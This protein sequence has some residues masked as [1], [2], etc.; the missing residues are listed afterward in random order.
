MLRWKRIV[1]GWML[2]TV[3][4]VARLLLRLLDRGNDVILVSLTDVEAGTLGAIVRD[5]LCYLSFSSARA[6]LKPSSVIVPSGRL[7]LR[8]VSTGGCR[9]SQ[10]WTDGCE[11]K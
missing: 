1:F 11:E 8:V 7:T 5:W 6:F 4:F 3:D 2:C 10:S 9:S